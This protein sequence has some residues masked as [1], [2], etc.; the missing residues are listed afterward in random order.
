MDGASMVDYPGYAEALE[1][2]RE[3]MTNYQNDDRKTIDTARAEQMFANGEAGMIIIGTW[4]LGA[5][6]DYNPDGNF[7][8]FTYPSEET[9]DE[10]YV[11]VAID[12]CWMI[13]EGTPNEEAALAFLE[14]ATR[15]EV[16]A[17]WCGSAS[18]LSALT[19][20][21]CDTLPDAAKDIANEI[22]TKKSTAWASISNFNGQFSTVYSD[23]LRDF[24]MDDDMTIDEFITAMDEGFATAR[25]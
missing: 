11:P 6:M 12:D 23:T 9:A 25:K 8:G 7:G 4:G 21:E 18:Q 24:A 16:N 20:V 2:W 5:I 19:G 1:Q 14:Y 13:S 3:I 10:C 15:P 17:K 22:A